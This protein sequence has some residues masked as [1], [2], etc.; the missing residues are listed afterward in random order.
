MVVTVAYWLTPYGCYCGIL[1]YALWLLLWHTDL[2]LMV[3]T[4]AYWLA[5]YG[6]YCGILTCTLW[7]L[8]WHTDLS[9]MVFTVAYWLATNGCYFGIL[10]CALWLLLWHT[11]LRLTIVA[12]TF[13]TLSPNIYVS[14]VWTIFISPFWILECWGGRRTYVKFVR[15]R[16]KDPQLAFGSESYSLWKWTVWYWKLKEGVG[17]DHYNVT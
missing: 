11:D 14:S 3:A 15:R 13:C 1:T 17:Y 8:L 12:N 5:P 7:L 10:T 6:C 9:L 16:Y 2:R 4:V